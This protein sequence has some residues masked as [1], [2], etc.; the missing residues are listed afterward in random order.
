MKKFF[1]IIIISL[2]F[3]T[4]SSTSEI[5]DYEI[6]GISVGDSLL[7]FFEEI[8]IKKDF[9]Y[10]NKKYFA[11]SSIKY[12][13]ENYDGIQF[14]AK[15]NDKRYKIVSIEG[16]KTFDNDFDKCLK[17][18]DKIVK[19]ILKDLGNPKVLSEEGK[20]VYDSTGKSKYYRTN[21]MLDPKAKYYN[22]SVS[23][24]DW[25]NELQAE[26]SDKLKVSISNNEFNDY[27]VKEAY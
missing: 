24:T 22:L 4:H 16:I 27:M 1:T 11:F 5:S 2:S 26:F 23:C 3:F 12:K 9:F 15:N 8:E 18:K 17:L 13:S 10:K 20:H 14:H 19:D 7:D 21:I 25:S 6:E